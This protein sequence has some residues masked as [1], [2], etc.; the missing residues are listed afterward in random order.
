MNKE[1]IYS[2]REECNRI[3][4]MPAY[5][6]MFYD[7][8]KKHQKENLES[9]MQEI[10]QQYYDDWLN[11]QTIRSILEKYLKE[12]PKKEKIKQLSMI[13]LDQKQERLWIDMILAQKI[14]SIIDF[15]N[16]Q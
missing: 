5:P 3:D 7:I 14:N 11:I 12:E 1:T 13:D 4:P 6:E 16:K 15:I 9:I 2:I 10:S 8:V